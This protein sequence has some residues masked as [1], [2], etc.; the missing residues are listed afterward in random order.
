[1]AIVLPLLLLI[2]FGIIDFGLL[3][4]RQ[5]VLTQ[6]AREAV[7]SAAVSGSP[8]DVGITLG[9]LGLSGASADYIP[10]DD[11]LPDQPA[12]V[13]LSYVYTPVTPL[14]G[15]MQYFGGGADGDYTL[16]ATGVLSCRG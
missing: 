10:C 7:R 4:N 3:L 16:T 9:R 11:A 5:I 12:T 1:M 6:G 14:G 15:L 13:T 2:L 8:D